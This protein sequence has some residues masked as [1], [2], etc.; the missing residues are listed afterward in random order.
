V[1][2]APVVPAGAPLI[3]LVGP[4][5]AGAPIDAVPVAPI[6]DMSGAKDAPTGP[7]LAGGPVAGQPVL[8]G[9]SAAH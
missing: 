9:P 6:L 4:V 1:P 3:A 7:A 2:V 8:P 5:A